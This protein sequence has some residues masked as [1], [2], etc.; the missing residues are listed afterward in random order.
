MIYWQYDPVG[1]G[2]SASRMIAMLGIAKA[3]GAPAIKSF[4]HVFTGS[5]YL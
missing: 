5:E 4:Y 1:C 2:Y 3:R